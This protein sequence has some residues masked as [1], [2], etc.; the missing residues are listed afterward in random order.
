M[1]AFDLLSSLTDTGS[2]VGAAAFGLP[3]VARRCHVANKEPT[4]A[5]PMEHWKFWV[6]ART[7]GGMSTD[8]M[9]MRH[10]PPR[11]ATGQH[12]PISATAW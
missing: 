3:P 1:V 8:I 2:A 9:P 6:Q 4:H 11:T 10:Q 12:T 5:R 7:M